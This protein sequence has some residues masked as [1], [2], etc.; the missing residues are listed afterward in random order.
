M[1]LH[2]LYLSAALILN[3]APIAHATP[4]PPEDE[5]LTLSALFKPISHDNTRFGVSSLHYTFSGAISDTINTIRLCNATDATCGTCNTA[6]TIITAGTPIPYSTGGTT[7]GVSPASVA[8]YLASQSM[9]AGSYN[10]GVYVQSST[11]NCTG[12]KC[13]TNTGSNAHLLCM[14]ATYSGG[15]VTALAQSDNGNAVLN[16]AAPATQLSAT[17]NT[18]ALQTSGT[19]RTITITNVG[20]TSASS[21]TYTPSPALPAGTSIAPA[22]CGSIAASGT[23]VLTI[24]PG[25][26]ASAA[27][28]NTSPTPIT[29]TIAGSNTNTLNPTTNVLTYASVYQS[30]YLFSI[31]DTTAASSSIG[32]KIAALIDQVDINTGIVWSSDGTNSTTVSYDIIPGIDETSTTLSAS[33]ALN[34]PPTLS[35]CNGATDGS[36]DSNNIVTYYNYYRTGGGTPPTPLTD[37]S[38]GLCT[39]YTI[40]SAGNAP[41]VA[42]NTCYTGWFLPSICEMGPDSGNSICSASP[43]EPNIV[44]NLPYL[45]GDGSS[46]S[47]C[48]AGAGCISGYYW[49]STEYSGL[50]QRLAWDEY[51]AS[52]ADGGSHRFGDFKNITYGVRCSRALTP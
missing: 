10:I 8:A 41:C 35:A 23:C 44:D 5:R 31:D 14:Q 50:P 7:Y 40:D 52:V 47:S 18:L 45:L 21:V 4:L 38:A 1:K 48:T 16:T 20:T 22:S 49:S 37:Y 2:P 29:L 17:V 11:S 28:Y 15:A 42:G 6:F 30:G 3:G 13:S 32:G 12:S 19:Q 26:T 27:A 36:C 25:A 46:G 43:V 34:P 9:A 51:F 39:N 24:T 33:P